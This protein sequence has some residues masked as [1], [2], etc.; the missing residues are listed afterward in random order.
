MKRKKDPKFIVNE[1]M[2]KGRPSKVYS[3]QDAVKMVSDSF[4]N[5]C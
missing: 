2:R 3:I 5:R 1:S 4:L